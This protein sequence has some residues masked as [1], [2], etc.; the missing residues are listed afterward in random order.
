MIIKNQT[1]KDIIVEDY[2][3]G[4]VLFQNGIAFYE[5]L[6]MTLNEVCQMKKLN[7]GQLIK[8]INISQQIKTTEDIFDKYPVTWIIKYL[9]FKHKI[10]TQQKLPYF[11]SLINNLSLKKFDNPILIKDLKLLFP[12]FI[13]E[14]ILHIHEEEDTFFAYVNLLHTFSK[15]KKPFS[16]IQQALE[17]NILQKFALEHHIHDDEM[18]GIRDLTNDYSLGHTP[19]LHLEVLFTELQAFENELRFHAHVEDNVLLPKALRLEQQVKN[20]LSKIRASN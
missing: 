16:K 15:E 6:E 1:I 3:I 10:F 11:A 14:F 13:E 18:R 2:S 20:T 19:N 17:E 8:S 9:M 12:L 4:S 7:V 5:H